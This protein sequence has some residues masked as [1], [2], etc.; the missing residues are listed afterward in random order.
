MSLRRGCTNER[1]RE[2]GR[3]RR[4]REIDELEIRKL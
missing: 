3:K 4:Q 1:G 2:Q